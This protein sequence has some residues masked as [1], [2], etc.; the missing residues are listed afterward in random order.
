M[1]FFKLTPDFHCVSSSIIHVYFGLY[2]HNHLKQLN[3][4][5][6][7]I[8]LVVCMRESKFHVVFRFCKFWSNNFLIEW[9]DELA[10]SDSSSVEE[11]SSTAACDYILTQGRAW[12]ISI[13]QRS[14]VN[15]EI[16]RAFMS[17]GAGMNDNLIYRFLS[18]ILN[19]SF[20]ILFW[21]T[22]LRHL[23]KFSF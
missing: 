15:E 12:T 20:I 5:S 16:S 22:S 6:L 13:T 1:W 21:F 14:V 18:L 10:S 17:S 11:I 7:Y 23:S 8:P 2:Y 9:Q 3:W 4:H 19:C